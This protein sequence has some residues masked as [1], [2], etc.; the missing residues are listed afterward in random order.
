MPTDKQSLRIHAR[1]HRA[2]LTRADAEATA[3]LSASEV[4]TLHR[5]LGRVLVNLESMLDS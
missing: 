3:G 2:T 5:L 4:A 1:S